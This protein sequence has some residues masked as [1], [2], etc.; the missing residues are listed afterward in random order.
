[1]KDY[2]KKIKTQEKLMRIAL[3]I[4]TAIILAGITVRERLPWLMYLSA[5]PLAV[6]LI[7]ALLIRRY[8]KKQ[9][10]QEK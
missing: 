7:N 2:D 8:E 5:A 9:R 10:E 1:M 4:A 6:M 3:V